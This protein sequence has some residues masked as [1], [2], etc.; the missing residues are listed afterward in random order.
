MNSDKLS[1]RLTAVA[2]F[3]ESGAVLADIGSDHAYL[4]CYLIRTG[5]ISKAIAG[6]VVKGPFES[7]KKNVKKEGLENNI[8]VRLGN[9]LQAVEEN[10][11]VDTI[12]IA[13]M[14]GPLIASILQEGNAKLG[15]VK[16]IITQPNIH[17]SSIR[18]WAVQNGWT[19]I[20]EEILKEDGK[21][22]E[23]IVLER[24]K[25]EYDELEMKFGPYLLEDKSPIFVEKWERELAEWKR[26]LDS[27]EKAGDTDEIQRR[28]E[29]LRKKIELAGRVLTN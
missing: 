17:S 12:T 2:S 21:I 23:I 24:G 11:G 5:I 3:V 8:I 22:Y 19:I 28:K 6:E 10:D 18:E 1:E 26:I 9:G 16:R 25:A 13:G 29:Q 4:P 7:A 20:E 15:K 14:G 27:L